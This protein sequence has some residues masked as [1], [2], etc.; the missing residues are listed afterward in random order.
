M[1]LVI[2]HCLAITFLALTFASC[3]DT[4]TSSIPDYSVYMELNLTTAPY[5]TFMNSYLHYF[6]FTS[7][8]G[9][10]I[11]NRIGYGGII[12]CTGYDG[13]YYAFDMSCPYE[14]SRTVLVYPNDSGQAVCE[15]CGSI[16]T[17]GYGIGDPQSGPAKETLKRYKATLSGY[18]LYITR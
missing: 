13:A 10:P 6:Y 18:I 3:R 17:L 14:A 11:T 7:L 8:T 4:V 1:K 12:V 2:K 16:F 9:L 5:T 15:K